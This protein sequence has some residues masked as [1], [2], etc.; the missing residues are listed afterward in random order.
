MSC[1]NAL[2]HCWRIRGR[3]T[4]TH[5]SW[6]GDGYPKGLDSSRGRSR[7]RRGKPGELK[8]PLG[9]SMVPQDARLS[10][11][12]RET[13]AAEN[14]GKTSTISWRVKRLIFANGRESF[15]VTANYS[16]GAVVRRRRRLLR[17]LK[18]GERR[19]P[20]SRGNRTAHLG[21][22]VSG[23]RITLTSSASHGSRLFL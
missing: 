9:A 6:M 22:C 15:D 13:C 11:G 21:G 8:R 10:A 12:P 14:A 16:S 3:R 2:P 18:V 23:R 19:W 5:T 20:G 17:L 1:P 7:H 4:R